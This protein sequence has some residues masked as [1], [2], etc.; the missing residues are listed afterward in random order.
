MAWRNRRQTNEAG[1][2]DNGIDAEILITGGRIH[3]VTDLFDVDA[4][5]VE[6]DSGYGRIPLLSFITSEIG[7]GTDIRAIVIRRILGDTT[8]EFERSE[9]NKR[10][11]E[12]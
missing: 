2:L 7:L 10:K 11:H 1:N 12:K 4:L 8:G 5:P 3:R 6:K 9:S